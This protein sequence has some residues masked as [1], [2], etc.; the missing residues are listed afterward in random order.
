[1]TV[2]ALHD[3]GHKVFDH[4]GTSMEG[5]PDE[6]LWQV[7]V[8]EK[9][10]FVTDKGFSSKRGEAH[11]GILIVRLRQPNRRKIH[12]KVLQ[13]ICTY[14]DNDWPGLMV[15]VRDNVQSS[16]SNRSIGS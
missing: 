15:V 4:R 16:W 1:M 9:A 13:A 2:N 12:D 8:H 3:L 14:M 10:L 5:L 6:H 7:V 11:F